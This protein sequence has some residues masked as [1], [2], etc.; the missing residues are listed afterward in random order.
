MQY[1]LWGVVGLVV[2]GVIGY[3][4]VRGFFFGERS[5]EKEDDE[6]Q[7]CPYE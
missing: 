4:A 6:Y 5:H 2:W 7:E 1:L 3:F